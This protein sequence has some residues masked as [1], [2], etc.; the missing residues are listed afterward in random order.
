MLAV[1][2]CVNVHRISSSGLSNAQATSVNF[3]MQ[4]ISTAVEQWPKQSPAPHQVVCLIRGCGVGTSDGAQTHPNE[5]YF[6]CVKEQQVTSV[7]KSILLQ[8][9]TQLAGV[10]SAC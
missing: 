10:H 3:L 7:D 2:R 9:A 8:R 5:Q 4:C 6:V 1:S